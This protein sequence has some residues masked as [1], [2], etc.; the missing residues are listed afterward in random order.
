LSHELKPSF[1]IEQFK[2]KID[3]W[4]IIFELNEDDF[5]KIITTLEAAKEQYPVRSKC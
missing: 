3:E 5:K 2:Y 4:N 1:E